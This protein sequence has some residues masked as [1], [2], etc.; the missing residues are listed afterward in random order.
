MATLLD[1]RTVS[2]QHLTPDLRKLAMRSY[3]D[4]YITFAATA[5]RQD[6]VPHP[7]LPSPTKAKPSI[8]KDSTIIGG[9][10]LE[11]GG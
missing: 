4:K 9:F 1:F 10:K 5:V 2:C 8:K 3:V 11:S 7:L 6:Y